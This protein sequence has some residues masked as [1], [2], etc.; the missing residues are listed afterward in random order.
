MVSKSNGNVT[1]DINFGG[2]SIKIDISAKDIGKIKEYVKT[3]RY[4][5]KTVLKLD[6]GFKNKAGNM[7]PV[8][9]VLQARNLHADATTGAGSGEDVV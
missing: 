5:N 2:G 9:L 7:S 1:T 8:N 6:C 4:T 3:H